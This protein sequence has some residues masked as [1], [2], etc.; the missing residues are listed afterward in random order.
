MK[1]NGKFW[2]SALILAWT[3]FCLAQSPEV[4][5]FKPAADKP[6]VD[7]YHL[8]TKGGMEQNSVN[9]ITQDHQGQIWY[10]TKDGVVRYDGRE[11]YTYKYRAGDPYSITDNFTHKVF[12]H[13]DGT[14]WVAATKGLSKYRP[15]TDDFETIRHDQLSVDAIHSISEDSSGMLWFVDNESNLY[16]YDDESGELLLYDCKMNPPTNQKLSFSDILITRDDRIFIRTNQPWFLEFNRETSEFK[17]FQFLEDEL[18]QKNLNYRSYASVFYEDHG[19]NILFGT[20]FGFIVKFNPLKEELSQIYYLNQSNPTPSSISLFVFEDSDQNLWTGTWGNGLFKMNTNE[21]IVHHF[22]PGAH[23]ETDISNNI[24]T[25]A[26]QDHAGYLWFG[27]E[28]TGIN[29]LKKNKKFSV[30][31]YAPDA[32][33]TLP[34]FPYLDVAVDNSDRVWVATDGGGSKTTI[35]GLYYF[36]K[37]DQIPHHTGTSIIGNEKRVFSLLYDRDGYLWVGSGNGLFKYHPVSLEVKHYPCKYSNDYNSPGGR[38]IISLCED[39]NGNIWMGA[40]RGGLTR[41]DVKNNKFYRF[42]P[43][44]HNPNSLSYQYVSAITCDSNGDI[45]VG[46][47]DGLNKFNPGTGDF[48]VFNTRSVDS[49]ALGSAVINCLFEND[50]ILWIGTKGGGLNEYDLQTKKFSSF[51]KR[52][53]LPD[54]NVRAINIDDH[55]N[56]W[57]STTHHISRFNPKNERITTYTG[58]DGLSN[59]MTV[60]GYGTQVLEFT[61]KFARKDKDGYL[62]FGGIGGMVFFHPDSLPQNEYKAPVFIDQLSVNG[63]SYQILENP[64]LELKPNQNNLTISLTLLNYIQPDKNQYAHFLENYDTS[65]IY[66]GVDHKIE[67]FD[68]PAGEYI[69]HYKGANNDGVWS[70]AKVPIVITIL[71]PFYQTTFFYML[72]IGLFILLILTFIFYRWYIKKQ[73]AKQRALMRYNTSNLSDTEAKKISEKLTETMLNE[74][75]YLNADLTLYK[76]A[77][78]LDTKPHNLSQVLNEYHKTGFHGF[79][80]SYRVKEATKMLIETDLKIIAVAYDSGFKSISTF[81]VAFK[82][83]TGMTPSRY[84]RNEKSS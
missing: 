83:E 44:E 7:F 15:L 74:K 3:S 16:Q 38:N 27:T 23:Q 20:H 29:I 31:A 11:F 30:L 33:S 22:M 67:Y 75:P 62:Y 8:R 9:S 43:D 71:T 56:L 57:L 72:S 68:L 48:T 10:S 2:V 59:Q 35:A 52:D 26:Y 36:N 66:D 34:P 64:E 4:R 61:E 19:G 1:H 54:N 81:N 24:V 60:E 28:F 65:W 79:I 80:N 32:S 84:R 12:V 53:G 17:A 69:F 82:K 45:W 49:N 39:N 6:D 55:G 51:Q 25:C 5:Y 77:E 18:W 76:L 63:T 78:V 73:L 58:S 42:M 46:T 50:G 21:N 40:I 14:I 13:S 70:E 41:F 47:L 37:G